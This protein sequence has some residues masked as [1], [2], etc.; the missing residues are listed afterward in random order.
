MSEGLPVEVVCREI[1]ISV[2]GFY[3]RRNRRPSARAV[4]HAMLAEVIRDVHDRS[5]QTSGA[6]RVHAELVLGRDMTVGVAPSSS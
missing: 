5:R 1:G 6:R 4:R 3:A 2:S